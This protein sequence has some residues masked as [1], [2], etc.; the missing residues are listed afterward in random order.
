MKASDR[1]ALVAFYDLSRLEGIIPALESSHALAYAIKTAPQRS[2]DESILINL[3][4]RGDKDM[5]YVL[6]HYPLEEY[7]TQKMLF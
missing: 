5:D 2:K 1:E 7:E 4:G 3:S 6:A